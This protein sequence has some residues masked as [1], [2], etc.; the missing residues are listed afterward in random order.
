MESAPAVRSRPGSM[1]CTRGASSSRRYYRHKRL[2]NNNS[3]AAT[4][5]AKLGQP[6]LAIAT[7]P[8]FV[9]NAG[10]ITSLSY[11]TPLIADA[12]TGFGGPAMVARTVQM[13]DRAGVAALHI[14]DQ[15]R[16]PHPCSNLTRTN[17]SMGYRSR[18]SVADI[19]SA[20]KSS[21]LRSSS[22]ASALPSRL[23]TPFRDATLSSSPVLI[24]LRFSGWTRQSG[25]Y[26]P[27]PPSELMLHLLR[28]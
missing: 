26:R 21:P 10:M 16:K 2:T 13:Y 20:S 11:S 19:S 23:A 9:Q 18:P 4:T 27:L 3:G 17:V 28:E 24:L 5:A 7:L 8:D 6:D 15:V 12:D 1:S 25:G 22:L 14:E